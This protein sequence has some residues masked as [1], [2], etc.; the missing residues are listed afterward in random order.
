M[1]IRKIKIDL[2]S[3]NP[4]IITGKW[5]FHEALK[6]IYKW[7]G[8]NSTIDAKLPVD[9]KTY[10]PNDTVT[11]D[12]TFTAN[13]IE[14]DTDVYY[15]FSG[16]DKTGTFIITTPTMINGT[17][18]KKNKLSV[19]YSWTNAP[20]SVSSK[21]PT[22]TK[23]YMPN[24]TVTVDSTYTSSSIEETTD[25][26]Y[27]F[28]GWS[29]T[30]TFNITADTIISGSWT[31]K[32]KLSVTY[33][34]ENAPSSMTSTVPVDNNKYM[35]NAAVTVDTKYT[36]KTAYTDTMCIGINNSINLS[37][38]FSCICYGNGKYVGFTNSAI[39][40][41][42]L[43]MPYYSTNG[44]TWT[45]GKISSTKRMWQNICYGKDRFVAIGYNMNTSYNLYGSNQIAYSTDGIN[46]TDASITSEAT[47]WMD[48]A[49][50]NSKFVAISQN[51]G[52][53]AYSTNGTS[54]TLVSNPGSGLW[55]RV[56][57]GGGKFVAIRSGGSNS[58]FAY[59]ENGTSWTAITVNNTAYNWNSIA[60]GNDM[61][62]AVTSTTT[63]AISTDGITWTIK[64]YTESC[65]YIAY[66][67][68]F[69]LCWS[70]LHSN[71]HWT[72]DGNTWSSHNLG[73]SLKCFKGMASTNCEF[74]LS[75][76]DSARTVT[77][78]LYD[79]YRQFSGWNKSNFNITSDTTITGSWGDEKL[80]D[81]WHN[82]KQELP[83][84][85]W[86]S[87]CYGNGK[88]VATG[89]HNTGAYSTD[90]ITWTSMTMS[91]S[92]TVRT[93]DTV[94]Y[95]NGKF[96][97]IAY[98][99]SI[100]SYSTNGINWSDSSLTKSGLWI[101]CFYGK[102][103][104][105][106]ILTNTNTINYSTDGIHWV[107]ATLPN[108]RYWGKG[109]YGNGKYIILSS[110]GTTFAYSDNG[111]TYTESNISSTRRQWYCIAYGNGVFVACAYV[112]N[113][114]AYSSNG[115]SWTEVNVG[116]NVCEW[117]GIAFGDGYF[118][119]I[120]WDN[121]IYGISKD[122]KSWKTYGLSTP[123]D[124]CYYICYSDVLNQFM[125]V[126]RYNIFQSYQITPTN[127]KLVS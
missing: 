19:T 102:D 34:W 113:V 115:T 127:L 88:Y 64:T 117:Y 92:S 76:Y 123:S 25:T 21:L 99:T 53:F 87:V 63:Y 31:E 73:N 22:D 95:G 50:K 13:S 104:F 20:D 68:H 105:V 111:I 8:A 38:E 82:V 80:F 32:N 109:C 84:I 23:K 96:V 59:S 75:S 17:W 60:Y 120:T 79:Y 42:S 85:P 30:G 77:V 15:T 1:A 94:C 72:H 27:Q 18:T 100:V 11:V 6:V 49:Y 83:G 56:C 112:S 74:I 28:S 5:V 54:W 46:W 45:A 43:Q 126:Y 35:P 14:E 71:I 51:Y 7:T 97:A 2:F 89:K 26:Y 90:G 110:V 36:N 106:A 16:W 66:G 116:N 101:N 62:I 98:N 67:N 47:I 24:T 29:K 40:D 103:K 81:T 61:F 121:G 48:I 125:S 70:N 78:S 114:F 118:I 10:L 91:T 107:G 52:Y 44:T 9:N 4:T 41:S 124:M 86:R 12:T 57:S 119:A 39:N 122:G 69:F 3:K 33:S 55:L 58:T 93:Y 65:P 108:S 37:K